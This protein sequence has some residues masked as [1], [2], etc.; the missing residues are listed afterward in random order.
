MH[1]NSW[2]RPTRAL[3]SAFNVAFILTA[4]AQTPGES[5]STAL[6]N[7]F[8]P[9]PAIHAT[10]LDYSHFDLPV[11]ATV[12]TQDDIRRYGFVEISEIFRI[13]PGFRI[14]KIG[15]ESRVSYHGLTVRQNRRMKLTING[16]NVLVG[17][18]AYIEFDR[19]PIELDDIVRITITRGPNGAT[20]GDNAFVGSIDFATVKSV[21]AS[22]YSARAGV[23]SE[24]RRKYG[25]GV[26]ERLGPIDLNFSAAYEHD[27][28]YDYSDPQ[29]STGNDGRAIKRAHLDLQR[30]TAAS[31]WGLEFNGYDSDQIIGSRS[32]GLSGTQKNNGYFAA[33]SNK[34]ELGADARLDWLVSYNNQDE[35][36]RSDGCLT[37]DNLA[38][39]N[40]I[41]TNPVLLAQ[42][43]AM[44]RAVPSTLGVA[45][46]N[47]CLYLDLDTK[48][49]RTDAEIEYER[50]VGRARFLLGSSA[51]YI[52]ARSDERWSGI[53]QTQR[54]YRAFAEAD[55]G[56]ERVHA[57]LGLMWQDSDN[58]AKSQTAGRAALNWHLTPSQTLRYSYSHS[59]RIPSL[60]ESETIWAP[61]FNFGQRGQPFSSYLLSFP[62]PVVRNPIRIKSETIDSHEIGYF[63]V[64]A[65]SRVEID[66]KLFHDT[67]HNP[68]EAGWWYWDPPATNQADFTLQGAELDLTARFSQHWRFR[69]HY[70]YLDNDSRRPFELGMHGTDAGSFAL[71]YDFAP[72]NTVTAAYYGNSKISGNSYD[73]YDLVYTLDK[74]V[75]KV[76]L[77]PQFIYQRH[78]GGRDGVK[79]ANPLL[80]DERFLANLN[81]FFFYLNVEY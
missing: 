21:G 47:T 45:P 29:K 52:E 71:S 19:L 30:A 10:R 14:V 17:D 77:R 76:R 12:I 68:V 49:S 24:A 41:I 9:E 15:D 7:E 27:G 79:N 78:V 73:R 2:R 43:A 1:R 22:A 74:R 25:L 20:F 32:L 38:K 8:V 39:M 13:V 63:G 53:R 64:L 26:A 69:A 31:T 33:L 80:S 16:K 48:S 34:R 18:G 6:A 81:Q 50:R 58:V 5:P 70:S 65:Q 23:G 42:L 3:L 56:W 61:V 57:S 44:A 55:Y 37:P 36:T 60:V 54:S 66:A 62:F 67:L 51:T 75:G 4:R 28:G 72:G 46:A 11:A 59:F 35:F 40:L